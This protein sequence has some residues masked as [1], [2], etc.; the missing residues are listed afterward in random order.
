MLFILLNV[1]ILLNMVIAILSSTFS[2]YEEFKEGLFSNVINQLFANMEWDDQ[3]G[4]LI[5]AKAPLNLLSIP[6]FPLFMLNLSEE[7]RKQMNHYACLIVYSPIALLV[8][9]VF[10]VL[11]LLMIPFIH[12]LTTFKLIGMV[13]ISDSLLQLKTSI[14]LL[15][16]H[17]TISPVLLLVS[18]PVNFYSFILNLYTEHG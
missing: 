9:A 5:C 2:F 17:L 18:L 16:Q 8:S 11:N 4:A 3:Y 6:M 14:S 12:C 13:F 15:L 7:R 10:L 1:V